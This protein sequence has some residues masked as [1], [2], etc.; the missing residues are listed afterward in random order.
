MTYPLNGTTAADAADID[1][2]LSQASGLWSATRAQPGD[3]SFSETFKAGVK[4]L[5]DPYL[6]QL[7]CEIVRLNRIQ[8]GLNPGKSCPAPRFVDPT[9]GIGLEDVVTPVRAF[10]FY[11]QHPLIVAAGA[12][13]FVV[14]IFT[15]VAWLG[16]RARGRR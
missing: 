2:L 7:A 13:T 3:G 1:R 12:A 8:A 15:V 4:I 5:E 6:P 10:Q 14:G 16:Y 9:R 11:K